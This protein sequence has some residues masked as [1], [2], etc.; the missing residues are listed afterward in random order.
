MHMSNFRIIVDV[1][2]C[3]EEIA[4][5]PADVLQAKIEAL[6]EILDCTEEDAERIF[7]DRL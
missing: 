5:D 6:A 3:D 4:F 1:A 7:L 2:I